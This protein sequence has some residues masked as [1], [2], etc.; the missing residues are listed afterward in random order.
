MLAGMTEEED[1][2]I[3][4]YT[5]IHTRTRKCR[6]REAMLASMTEEEDTYM[7]EEHRQDFLIG[8]CSTVVNSITCH[9]SYCRARDEPKNLANER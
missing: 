5:E 4:T 6:E 9:I 8:S 3:R 1:T 2:C 7:T